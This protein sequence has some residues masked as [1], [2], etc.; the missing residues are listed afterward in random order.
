[1]KE[2]IIKGLLIDDDPDDRLLISRMLSEPGWPAT[3]NLAWAEDLASGLKLLAQGEFEIV[4]L[5]LMLPDSQGLE[6]VKKVIPQAAGVPVVVLTGLNDEKMGYEAVMSGAQDYQV[7]GNIDG[8]AFKR[9]LCYAVERQRLLGRL[10][11]MEQLK[12]E[13]KERQRMDKMKDELMSIVS[14]EMR[15]PLTIIKAVV[16]N[17]RDGLA[18]RLD[19]QQKKLVW[20]ENR[21]VERLEKIIENILDLSRLESGKAEVHAQAINVNAIVNEVASGYQLVARD[22]QIAIREETAPSLPRA[23]ADPDLV[24]QVISNLL[25]NAIRF[26]KSKILIRTQAGENGGIKISVIDDGPGISKDCVGDLFSKFVQVNRRL[27]GEGYKGT[28][29]GLAICKE[30]IERQNGKIWV[31]CPPGGGA[32]FHFLLPQF[33]PAA[34]LEHGGTRESQR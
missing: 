6:T 17:F 29:L 31:E 2:Q 33:K 21:G 27:K 19:E 12:A 8:Q 24:T 23:Y 7:K 16:C 10:V 9:V 3:I 15:S 14:H 32:Q 30:I 1:M 34:V 28:G 4:L 26:T 22:H 18:G 11:K 5:D 13:I 25:D 20:L